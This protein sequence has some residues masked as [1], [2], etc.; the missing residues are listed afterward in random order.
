MSSPLSLST[1]SA[2]DYF[3]LLVAD[4][5][6]FPLLEAAVSIAQDEDPRLDVQGV[7]SRV[8]ELAEKLRRRLPADTPALQRLRSATSYFF[9]ELGFSGNVNDYYERGNSLLPRVLDTRRGIPI[10]LAVLFIEIARQVD[11]NALGVSFPG[12]FLIKVAMPKGDVIIDPFTG[13][14]LSREDLEERLLP[15]RQR[16]LPQSDWPL[17]LFL[18]AAAPRDILARMLRNLKEIDR[19]RCDWMRMEQTQS[20]MVLLL[21]EVWEERRDHALILAELGQYR[22]AAALM[23]QYLQQRPDAPDAAAL[24]RHQLAWLKLQ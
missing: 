18:H 11:L 21:P 12:H 1:P 16:A 23:D 17:S 22:R 9:Q 24:R 19:S 20:R 8:D 7:V 14:S 13:A 5:K 6:S 15:Y 10:S 3:G 2:L 4:D